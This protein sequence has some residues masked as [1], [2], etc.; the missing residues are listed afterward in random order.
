VQ[1]DK[2][3]APV[4]EIPMFGF[5]SWPSPIRHPAALSLATISSMHFAHSH[6][7]SILLL[8]RVIGSSPSMVGGAQFLFDLVNYGAEEAYGWRLL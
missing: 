7:L 5:T 3:T 1:G 2:V 6:C 8:V 4:A